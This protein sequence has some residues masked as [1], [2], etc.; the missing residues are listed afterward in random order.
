MPSAELTSSSDSM[1]S[2]T[3]LLPSQFIPSPNQKFKL[4][5]NGC[6]KGWDVVGKGSE[7][8]PNWV[9]EIL[10]R[11]Y[12]ITGRGTQV[13]ICE[14]EGG[15]YGVIKH[16]WLTEDVL[17]RLEVHVKQ[18]NVWRSF[19]RTNRHESSMD[20]QRMRRIWNG[21]DTLLVSFFLS[22]IFQP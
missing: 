18:F 10:F 9:Q 21:F 6:L 2:S 16:V 17:K 14:L 20:R 1:P 22:L 12:S 13:W 7:F 8:K 5:L 3:M 19:G 11:S 15:G 4:D